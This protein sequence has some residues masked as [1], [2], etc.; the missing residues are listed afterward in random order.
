MKRDH[1]MPFGARRLPTAVRASGS[2]RR[3]RSVSNCCS[4]A[5]LANAGRGRRLARAAGGAC[6]GRRALRLSHRRRPHR[7]RSRHRAATRTTC[8]APARSIDPLAFDWPDAGWRGRPWHEAVIYELHVG[9]FTPEGTFAA[10]IERLDDLVALGI[11]AIELMP[12]ADFPGRRGWGYDGVLLFAP[13]AAYG[14]PDDLKQLVAAAH[15]RGLMVLLDVVY[16]HFGPDG[17]YLHAYAPDFFNADVHTPW[18]AAINFDGPG[19]RTVRDFFIHNALYWL[20]EFHFDGLRIDA[21]HAMHDRSALHFI[22]ELAQAVRDGPGRERHVHLVLENELNDATRLRARRRTARRT[23]H[24]AVERRRAP[25]AA[26][27]DQR[28]ARRLLRRLRRAAGCICSAVRSPRVSPTRASLAV[29]RRA[30]ARHAVDAPAAAGLRQLAADARP[31][32]QPRLRRTHRDAR[33]RAAARDALRAHARLRAAVAAAPPML[34]MGEE[35]AASTPFL[36]FC[37]FAGDL[38][39]AVTDGRRNEFRRFARFTDPARARAHPRSE[40]R[41]DLP[42][43]Q[44]RLGANAARRRMPLARAVPAVCS[45]CAASML[46][47]RLAGAASGARHGPEPGLL[48]VAWPLAADGRRLL[49]LLANLHDAAATARRLP[50][51][52]VIYDSHAGRSSAAR[53]RGRCGWRSRRLM[54]SAEGTARGVAATAAGDHPARHLPRAVARRLS[55]QR[56]RRRSCPTWRGSA[57]ATSTARRSCA[58]APAACTATTS[59]TTARSTPRSAR[60]PSSTRSSPRCMRTTWAC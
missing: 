20:E 37:D 17:N 26:R 15:A 57:S 32:R 59:S 18:G 28:R 60:A 40:R 3:P 13:D 11:T 7:A 49:H 1:E 10:A 16:N 35:C 48:A 31:G 58:R 47:P 6:R 5:R 42:A 39:R 46:V 24:R 51:G 19:S 38:A 56:R 44:A 27:A 12:V 2:G 50:A 34:F 29:S 8:T 23:G 25:R 14:T 4:T 36:Y 30:A 53:R 55:L 22:D 41:S 43:Q 52:A 33:A 9:C 21:V 54:T 45:A